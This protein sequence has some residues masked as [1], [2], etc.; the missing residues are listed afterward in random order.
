MYNNMSG[1]IEQFCVG[2]V[3]RTLCSFF[4]S[5]SVFFCQSAKAALSKKKLKTGVE[6]REGD[7][8]P[9]RSGDD[10][11]ISLTLIRTKI[12]SS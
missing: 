9:D 6:R 5:W 7:S 2:M 11:R 3:K 12:H 1:K 8:R 4:L 10:Y